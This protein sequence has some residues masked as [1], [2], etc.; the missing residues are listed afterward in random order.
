MSF[1]QVCTADPQDHLGQTF[2]DVKA[3]IEKLCSKCRC[4]DYPT[5]QK[6]DDVISSIQRQ[7]EESLVLK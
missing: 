4:C 6:I 3:T 1:G 5:K 7:Q 2:A